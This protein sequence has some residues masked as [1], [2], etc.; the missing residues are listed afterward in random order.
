MNTSLTTDLVT[1][2]ESDLGQGRRSGRWTLFHCP[3]PGHKHGDKKSSLAVTN[4]D[5]KRDAWWKCFACDRHGGAIKW[6]MEYRGMSYADALS[7]LNISQPDTESRHTFEPPIQIADTPPRGA[8]QARAMQL[9]KRSEA[10]LWDGRGKSALVWLR[11]RGLNDNTIHAARLGYIPNAFRD[12]A[13][14]W[15]KPNDDLRPL[16]FPEGIL[17]PG[18]VASR[19]WYLKIR[20]LYLWVDQKYKHV[21]GGRQALYLADTLVENLPAVFCEGEFDALLLQQEIHDLARVI[22]LASATGELNLAT[23]GLYLLRPSCFIL[24]HDMDP[25][26]DRGAAKLAWLRNSQRLRIPMIK[27]D[28]KD[29]TDF[30]KNGG[31]LYDLIESA[32]HVNAQADTTQPG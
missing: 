31:N 19:V 13:D 21:R 23:W 32:L 11:A 4:G 17:I 15:G 28:D 18:I 29:L 7:V 26:G 27:P 6:L 20:P 1:L 9:I 30:H 5:G 2:I 10:A 14:A 22:T 16:Y 3:F 25:A 12:N 8:W 24:A